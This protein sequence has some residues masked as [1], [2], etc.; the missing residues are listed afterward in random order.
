MT[1]FNGRRGVNVS[2]F[3]ANGNT[4]PSPNDVASPEDNDFRDFE[5]DLARFTN[6]DFTQV[7]YDNGG[8][9]NV[10]HEGQAHLDFESNPEESLNKQKDEVL[11][12]GKGLD[13]VDGTHTS[14]ISLRQ[15]IHADAPFL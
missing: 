1:S 12:E 8:L 5:K 11:Q 10:G 4:I 9:F 13:F 6:V 14:S 15:C 3:L 2:Q 7:D